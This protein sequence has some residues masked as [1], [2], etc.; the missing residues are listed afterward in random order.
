MFLVMPL[1]FISKATGEYFYFAAPKYLMF[2]G[3]E[4]IVLL[5]IS[6]LTSLLWKFWRD[7]DWGTFDGVFYFMGIYILLYATSLG[8]YIFNLF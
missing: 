8:P 4:Y 5:V 6:A 2:S 1:T 7:P 3:N